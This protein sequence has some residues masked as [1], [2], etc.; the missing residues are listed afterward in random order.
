MAILGRDQILEEIK[1]GNIEIDPFNPSMV[2]PASI[3]LHL[4]NAF[5]VFVHLPN[6]IEIE[7]DLDFKA[8]TKGILIPEGESITLLPGQT[9][10]GITK[11]RVAIRNGLAGWLEGRS[12]F[13]RVG[14]LIHISASFMQPGI[15][16]HQVL[17]ISNFGPIPLKLVP[18]TAV[19]QMIFQR[20]EEPGVYQGVFA[21]QNP[22][23]FWQG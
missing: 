18:G 2:G 20:C 14:L 5:R 8:A 1:K 15:N 22:D 12:R 13:A 7:T 23:T 21:E 3:D 10:L 17:E 16:N 9:M 11:E 19:C 6:P 4:S